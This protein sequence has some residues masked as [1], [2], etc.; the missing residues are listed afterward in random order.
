M[1][2]RIL[3]L[4]LSLSLVF[5]ACKKDEDTKT[6]DTQTSQILVGV[7]I[8]GIAI[9]GAAQQAIDKYGTTPPSYGAVGSN[10]T[11]FLIYPG[12]TVYCETTTEPTFNAQM[13][14]N[15]IT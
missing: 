3:L 15:S 13:K 7:G 6:D 8:T 4:L 10:Y 1:T 2:S 9:G 11:H 12:V 5:T 14:V